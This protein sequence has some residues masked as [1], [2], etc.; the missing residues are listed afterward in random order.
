MTNKGGKKLVPMSADLAAMYEAHRE[1]YD[2]GWGLAWYLAS[3]LCDRFHES[4]GIVFETILHD[5]LGYYGI[6]M[7]ALPCKACGYE[8]QPRLGRFTMAGNVEN[9]T[10]GEPGGHGLPLEERAVVHREAT[11]SLVAAAIAHMRLPL[12]S[13]KRHDTCRHKRRG[14]SFCLMFR[15]A[16]MVALR[17]NE[18]ESVG[19]CNEPLA[20]DRLLEEHDPK[21]GKKDY[22]GAFYFSHEERVVL[23]SGD[24]R[25]LLSPEPSSSLWERYMT[26][27]SQVSLARWVLD[28]LGM[29]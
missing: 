6:G 2:Q 17:Y 18:G 12:R 10:T 22:P 21:F 7:R 27:E 14:A 19:V 3:E 23:I 28:Q 11:D 24:G 1:R 20:F 15:L 29:P 16:S 26:G 5:G 4:H 8:E 25:V 13:A 9:W